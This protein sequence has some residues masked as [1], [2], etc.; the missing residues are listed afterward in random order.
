MPAKT[1]DLDLNPRQT[2]RGVFSDSIVAAIDAAL[3]KETDTPRAYIGAS[4]VGDECARRVQLDVWGA[5][6][7]KKPQPKSRPIDG[8]LR[9]I[10]TRGH[11]LETNMAEWL[12]LAGFDL[13]TLNDDGY[14]FGFIT[15]QGQIRGH[16]D[17]KIRAAPQPFA[18]PLP[19]IWENK[20]VNAKGWRSV[21][22]DGVLKAYPKYDAQAQLY[23]AYLDAKATLFTFLNA[24]T[25]EIYAEL[26]GF[27]AQRAQAASDR[28][29]HILTATR[30]GDL[31]PKAAGSGDVYPC[32]FCR[33]RGECWSSE[34][35]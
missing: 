24:D 5:F 32:A 13:V 28:A 1:I 2:L 18:A 6:H 17:G 20:V 26:V 16:V 35:V 3:E 21:S 14:P 7:P 19:C 15:G 9:R 27:D 30:A 31:L 34:G 33:W 11:R 25:C 12:R 23:M 10:F 8:K 29:V 4:A 22:K